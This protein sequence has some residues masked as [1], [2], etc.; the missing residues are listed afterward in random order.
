MAELLV[1]I[2]PKLYQKYVRDE[3]G[4]QV[5]YLELRKALY[6]TLMAALLFWR[7]LTSKLTEWRFVVNPFDS[8]V[9]NKDINGKRRIVLWH[10]DDLKISHVNSDVVTSIIDLLDAEFGKEAPLTKM[11]GKI[12]DYLGMTIDFSDDGKVKFSMINYVENMLNC[13]PDDMEGEAV[14]PASQFLFD[15][16]KT[17]ENL[18]DE[19]ADLFHHNT[20]KL[21]FLCK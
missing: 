6:G 12:H 1:R 11:R 8:C 3:G 4:K 17:A 10:V 19:T 15:V 21:L 2:D 14:S 7:L 5:L 18:D 20:A 9:M 16:N 13:L